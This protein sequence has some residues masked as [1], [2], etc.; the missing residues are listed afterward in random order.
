MVM[1]TMNLPADKGTNF[2]DFKNI[3]TDY[4]AFKDQYRTALDNLP[5]DTPLVDKMLDEANYAFKLNQDLFASLED[6]IQQTSGQKP[7]FHGYYAYLLFVL[8]AVVAAFLF[9]LLS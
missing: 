2:Y 1:R 3:E 9:K 4:G 6:E 5:V 7:S 8:V